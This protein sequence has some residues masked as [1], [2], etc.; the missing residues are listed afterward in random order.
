MEAWRRADL[1]MLVPGDERWW[2]G[3]SSDQHMGSS[4]RESDRRR[5]DSL[6]GSE[7]RTSLLMG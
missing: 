5:P 4:N 6:D 7:D 2:Q 3:K 1:G